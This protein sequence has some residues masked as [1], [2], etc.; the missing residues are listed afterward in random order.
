MGYGAC[1]RYDS[2]CI[3]LAAGMVQH[4]YDPPMMSLVQSGQPLRHY[5]R[6]NNVLLSCPCVL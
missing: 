4:P 6:S 5:K 2:P 3:G 1:A